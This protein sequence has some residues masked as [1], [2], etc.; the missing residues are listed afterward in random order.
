ML[1]MSERYGREDESMTHYRRFVLGAVV[2]LVV[3]T[4][5]AALVWT[6]ISDAGAEVAGEL[7]TTTTGTSSGGR[8]ASDPPSP[9]ATG[10]AT[11]P[12]TPNP[13]A[14]GPAPSTSTP[15]QAADPVRRSW[16]GAAG[17]VVAE[18]RGG[19]ISLSSAQPNSG[20]WIEVDN[21][22]PDDLRVEFENA[23]DGRVRVEARCAD[24]TPS[25]AVDSD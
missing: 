25:F 2:W 15:D 23:D 16:R 11:A 21:A 8:P 19:A 14:T 10:T 13:T 4:A 17:V 12:Q 5:G 9:T 3:V 20:W 24:G 7:P 6:V 22:G 1:V 18:C